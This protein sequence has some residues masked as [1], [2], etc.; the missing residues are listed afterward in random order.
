MNSTEL[1]AKAN[2][3][4][5]KYNLGQCDK[6]RDAVYV[7]ILEMETERTRNKCETVRG[8]N[9]T[10]KKHKRKRPARRH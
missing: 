9:G 1:I 2:E 4:I 3:I 7:T 6:I 8:N 5:N 10:K